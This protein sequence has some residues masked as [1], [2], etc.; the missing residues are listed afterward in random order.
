MIEAVNA[1]LR[2]Q[3]PQ[4]VPGRSRRG[5]PPA[6]RHRTRP[7]AAGHAAAGGRRPRPRRGA[8]PQL[9]DARRREGRRAGHAQPPHHDAGRPERPPLAAP[10]RSARSSRPCPY[11]SRSDRRSLNRQGFVAPSAPGSC[12]SSSPGCSAS[13]N[14][15]SSASGSCR[16]RPWRWR[17]SWVRRPRLR[18]G[19]WIHPAVLVAGD[20]GR[21]DLRIEHLGAVRSASFALSEDVR[22]AACGAATRPACPVA[23]MA[24]AGVHVDRLPADGLRS[25]HRA[26]RSAG[27][28]EPRSA[29]HGPGTH[30]APRRRRGLR[31]TAFV[32]AR[33]APAR[34]GHA[35][36]PAPGDGSPTRSG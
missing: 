18:A 10:T 35:R 7:V 14:C 1:H 36:R 24:S 5:E 13:S 29:R 6:S 27:G 4:G 22:T 11:R 21:V 23:P 30:A 12:R 17:S 16:R 28:R 20:V 19:R 15:S 31:R 34:P 8:W 2:R 25:R 33:H 26:A 3:R 9:R 32:P